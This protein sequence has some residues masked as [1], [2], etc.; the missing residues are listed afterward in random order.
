MKPI[1][2]TVMSGDQQQ[3]LG[4]GDYVGDVAVFVLVTPQ[5]T[6]FS[7]HDATQPPPVVPPGYELKEIGENPKIILDSGDTV[8]GCQV[9]WEPITLQSAF[10]IVVTAYDLRSDRDEDVAVFQEQCD[11]INDA[12]RVYARGLIRNRQLENWEVE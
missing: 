8:Y 9:W 6:L 4:E 11:S 10:Q 2:V 7:M 12:I 5:N 3:D 1:R